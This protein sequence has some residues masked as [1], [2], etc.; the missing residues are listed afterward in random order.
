[1]PIVRVDREQFGWRLHGSVSRPQN[2]ANLDSRMADCLSGG[3][4]SRLSICQG[5]A[6]SAGNRAS[7]QFGKFRGKTFRPINFGLSTL[8]L[9]R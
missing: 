4:Q 6:R 7:F 1:M 9:L 8:F 3:G 2:R 5:K